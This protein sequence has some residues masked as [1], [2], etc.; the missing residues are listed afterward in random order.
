MCKQ[1]GNAFCTELG[2]DHSL[3][4]NESPMTKPRW[5]VE[6]YQVFEEVLKLMAA[7]KIENAK[8]L[9]ENSPDEHMR[10][11]F[12]DHAQNSGVWRYKALGRSTPEPIL[13]LDPVKS[14]KKYEPSIFVRDN[15]QCRYCS[16]P[17]IPK[18]IFRDAH[19]QLGSEALPLG[20]TNRTRSG[21]YLMFVATLD[22]VLPWSLGGRTN[23]SNLVT[24]CWSCNYGKANYTVEQLGI[25]NPFERNK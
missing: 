1:K 10:I 7:E 17:A 4:S 23:E 19:K 2:S 18:K 13:P 15:F 22:H 6:A 5:I 21:F 11:W 8:S 3:W 12:D 14:F 20:K 25:T 24:C 16:N 9:L